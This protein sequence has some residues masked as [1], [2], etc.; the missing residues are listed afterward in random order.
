MRPHLCH[1]GVWYDNGDEGRE[2]KMTGE[3]VECGVR[4]FPI[5]KVPRKPRVMD[6]LAGQLHEWDQNGPEL[7]A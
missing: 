5:R 7:T 1:L 3:N 4:T 2:A 6:V